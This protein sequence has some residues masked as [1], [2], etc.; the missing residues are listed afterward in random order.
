MYFEGLAGHFI[1]EVTV[2]YPN[3]HSDYDGFFWI[4]NQD[5]KDYRI[6]MVPVEATSYLNVT[7]NPTFIEHED[8][9]IT[10]C[11]AAAAVN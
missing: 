4:Q 9:S 8:G 1:G 11:L 3:L 6:K 5:S 10:F 7:N 2:D